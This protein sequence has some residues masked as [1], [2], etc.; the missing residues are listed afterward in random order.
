LPKRCRDRTHRARG[1]RLLLMS[2][3]V[4]LYVPR[5]A[6][7]LGFD[8]VICTQVRWRSDGRLDGRLAS[9]NCRG[10][11]KRRCLA[12]VIARDSP[13][14]I[15]AYGNSGSDLPTW[16][17]AHEAYLV[18]GPAHTRRPACRRACDAA[19]RC[20]GSSAHDYIDVRTSHSSGN[21][22]SRSALA[23]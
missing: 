3:S 21:S 12:A 8:E 11:E 18:N 5:I 9:A 14:R 15:Y 16:Q 19:L 23:R 7:A 20:A 13:D 22:R 10:E 6:Q 2:A 17:L 1:D 4:D